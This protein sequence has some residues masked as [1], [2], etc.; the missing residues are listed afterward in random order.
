MKKVIRIALGVALISAS[1]YA[2]ANPVLS[3]QH[4][5]ESYGASY[6]NVWSDMTAALRGRGGP[7]VAQG[8]KTGP[9]VAQGSRTGANVGRG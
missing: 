6:N 3:T 5:T 2:F 1:T 7:N 9:N 8:S 4:N